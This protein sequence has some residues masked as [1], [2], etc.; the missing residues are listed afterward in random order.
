[1]YVIISTFAEKGSGHVGDLLIEQSLKDLITHIKGE[2]EFLSVFRE[3]SLEEHLDAVNDSR[4]VLMP[5]FAI[6]DTPMHPLSYRLVDDLKR[7][8]V[9]LIPVGANYNVYPG[10]GQSRS[11]LSYSKETTDFLRYI[12]AQMEE[13]SCREYFTARILQKHGIT[14]TVM[15][16]DPTWYD[17][18]C[19]GKKMKRPVSIERLVFTPPL[20]PYYRE[21]A[22]QMIRMLAIRFPDA[23]R[24]CAMQ[25]ADMTTAKKRVQDKEFTAEPSAALSPEVAEKNRRIRSFAREWGFEVKEVSHDVKRIEFFASCDLHVGYEC[26]A[27]LY[28]LKKRIPSVLVAEDARGVGFGYTLGTGGFH[29]FYRP[30][31]QS[32]HFVRK[33]VTSGYATTLEEYSQAPAI[34]NLHEIIADFVEEELESGFRRYTGLADYIDDTYESVMK[35]FIEALP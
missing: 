8:R 21:Q 17:I 13:F 18:H 3:S 22:E 28:F 6:R 1:M 10:D 29:G 2:H 24:Y 23:Q 35:P 19:I 7:V 27:H 31:S 32:P 11:V 12:A 9:P 25:I 14:N 4:A 15:T 34:Q 30:Q 26:H 16:G 20:S 5:A 33:Q